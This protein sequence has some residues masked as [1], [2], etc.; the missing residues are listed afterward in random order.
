MDNVKVKVPEFEKPLLKLDKEIEKL[1][2]EGREGKERKKLIKK[3]EK[4][5]KEIFSNL[6]SWQKVQLA[7][8]PRRPHTLDFVKGIFDSYEE[9]HG[10]RYFGDDKAVVGGPAKLGDETVFF[11]GNQKGM[12]TKDNIKRNFGMAHPE[13][14]RKALRMMKLAEKFSF[15]VV[16]FIDTPGAYPG[17]K[18]EERGQAEAIATNL[19]E[20]MRLKVPVIAVIIGEGGSGGALGIGVGDRILMLE[21]SVY[22][23]CTPEACSSI[24]WKDASMAEEAAENMKLTA[25][26][27]VGLGI[28]DEIVEEPPGG[29]HSN[30][31]ET[32]ENLKKRIIHHLGVLKRTNN[33]NIFQRRYE[34]YRE[35]KFY[36]YE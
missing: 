1:S 20:M 7:R 15:P 36:R 6:S 33:E 10:D 18:A 35:I 12:N 13:G 8:H 19:K 22:F 14:Y 32:F 34:K 2:P 23:V 30:Y 17:I 31:E 29:A 28:V 9:F 4:R 11:V 3:R 16:T 27:L 26:D 25:R 21:N 5:A 24:L